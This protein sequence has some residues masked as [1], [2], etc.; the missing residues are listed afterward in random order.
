MNTYAENLRKAAELGVDQGLIKH[1]SDGSV[2]SAR[3]LAGIVQDEG[4]HIDEMNEAWHKVEE[5]K[6]NLS[7]E[8]ALYSD[9]VEQAKNEM[10]GIA[11]QA[12]LDIGSKLTS[13]LANGLPA[14]LA[15]VDQYTAA[16][17]GIH[18]PGENGRGYPTTTGYAG[19]TSNAAAGYA[20]VGENGPELV[21]LNG[22]ERILSAE[23]TRAATRQLVPYA[24]YIDW[25]GG[26]A[27]GAGGRYQTETTIIVPV[28]LDGREIARST[29][30]YMG[31]EMAFEVM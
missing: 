31:E 20:I 11:E 17:R 22:G 8:L 6:D 21:Y 24:P 7:G 12:G 18:A 1:L 27:P 29:A 4:Q 19:G 25:T 9:E 13:S 16:L 2:E 15:V 5:G 14:F 3:I 10:V 28:Q 30:T 23:E 26:T